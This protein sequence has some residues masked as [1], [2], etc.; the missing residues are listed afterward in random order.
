[1]KKLALILL[2]LAEILLMQGCA[3]LGTSGKIDP[4]C[5]DP[6]KDQLQNGFLTLQNGITLECQ[7]KNYTSKMSCADIKDS[8]GAD[9]WVCNNGE[10]KILFWFDENKLLKGHKTF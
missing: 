10:K 2:P 4:N 8:T 1:M 6:S 9:G 3:S 5:P 7:I